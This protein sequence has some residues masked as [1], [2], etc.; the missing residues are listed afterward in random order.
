MTEHVEHHVVPLRVYMAV[1]VALMGGTALTVGVAFVDLGALN[2]VAAVGIAVA[3]ATLVV[4]FFMHVRYETS[5][6]WL[7]VSAGFLWLGI[8]LLFTITDYLSRG[9]L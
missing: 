5:L 1:F 9:W 7:F 2:T 8:L 6:I 4:L 3:K